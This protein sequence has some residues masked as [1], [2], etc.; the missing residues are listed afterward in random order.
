MTQAEMW[1]IP[2]R[3]SPVSK[4]TE[5]ERVKGPGLS[6]EPDIW[7]RMG[8]ETAGRYKN[9]G[10]KCQILKRGCLSKFILSRCNKMTW[11][12]L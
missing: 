3:G 12:N 8:K 7:N 10:C 2:G 5:V 11:D 9:Y 6:G 4:G 1:G